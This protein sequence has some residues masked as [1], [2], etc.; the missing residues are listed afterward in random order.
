[1]TMG[2]LELWVAMIGSLTG[3]MFFLQ[4]A[5]PQLPCHN[6][7][8]TTAL[9]TGMFFFVLCPICLAYTKTAEAFRGCGGQGFRIWGPRS[10]Q[11]PAASEQYILLETILPTMRTAISESISISI[12]TPNVK[13][14]IITP[15]KI[16]LNAKSGRQSKRGGCQ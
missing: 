7:L 1:M 5:S 15:T 10:M 13:F 3:E 12:S 9:P 14:A 6:C 11:G 2:T 16:D 8:A 4:T